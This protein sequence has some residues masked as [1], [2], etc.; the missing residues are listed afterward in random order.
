MTEIQET[1]LVRVRARLGLARV[2]VIRSRLYFYEH[3]ESTDKSQDIWMF[4][5]KLLFVIRI[6][7]G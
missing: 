1:I 6:A 4:G 7:K 3:S 2:R 5:E